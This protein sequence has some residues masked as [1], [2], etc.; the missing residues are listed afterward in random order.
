MCDLSLLG[1]FVPHNSPWYPD[2]GWGPPCGR[3]SV[4][5]ENDAH[6]RQMKSEP[7]TRASPD[8]GSS[9]AEPCAM[10]SSSTDVARRDLDRTEDTERV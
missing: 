5:G 7:S 6:G 3:F 10:T 1:L 2:R 4:K 9:V 8:G